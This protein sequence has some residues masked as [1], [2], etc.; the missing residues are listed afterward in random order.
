MPGMHAC[1]CL[2]GASC[3]EKVHLTLSIRLPLGVP[4]RCLALP[5]CIFNLKGTGGIQI[6]GI[7]ASKILLVLQLLRWPPMLDGCLV[8]CKLQRI[9]HRFYS[10]TA[11]NRVRLLYYVCSIFTN[12]KYTAPHCQFA[13]VL[14]IIWCTGTMVLYLWSNKVSR[15]W[16]A[17]WAAF[18][19]REVLGEI[20][21]FVLK[22]R[23]WRAGNRGQAL[24]NYS[25]HNQ[26]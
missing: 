20:C 13:T 24:Q 19:D 10:T 18:P 4:R 1:N 6:G 21:G 7:H 9:H 14:S 2:V 12:A 11:S 8:C 23:Q 15:T 5:C 16:H 17:V 3:R 25:G 26:A 22:T